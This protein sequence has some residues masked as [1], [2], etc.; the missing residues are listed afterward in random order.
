MN[1]KEASREIRVEIRHILM[2]KWDPIGVK[3]EPLAADEYDSY[4]GEIFEMLKRK[5]SVRQLTEYLQQIETQN[6]GVADAKGYPLLPAKDRASAVSA[7]RNLLSLNDSESKE[8]G[9]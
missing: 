2:E 6:M 8:H 5:V 4:I 7:L 1:E 3:D 9:S